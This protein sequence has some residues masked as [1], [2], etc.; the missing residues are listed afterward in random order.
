MFGGDLADCQ[1]DLT[2]HCR[3]ELRTADA[4]LDCAHKLRHYTPMA[5]PPSCPNNSGPSAFRMCTA[6]EQTRHVTCLV[7]HLL[8]WLLRGAQACL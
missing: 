7:L 3:R 6:C 1:A 4:A 2:K 8:T 5:K